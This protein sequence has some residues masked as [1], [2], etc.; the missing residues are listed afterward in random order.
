MMLFEADLKTLLLSGSSFALLGCVVLL[1]L[2]QS[3]YWYKQS[4]LRNIP[5]P[6]AQSF[7]LGALTSLFHIVSSTDIRPHAGNLPQVFGLLEGWDFH[8]ELSE[9]YGRVAKSWGFFGV[10]F[11]FYFL[12]FRLRQILMK[13]NSTGHAAAYQ[14]PK[15][16]VQHPDQGPGNL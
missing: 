2:W 5:G 3:R 10:S 6:P 12:V 14:R 8:V 7:A 15:S 13:A 1:V 9:T 4:H 11:R 16:T